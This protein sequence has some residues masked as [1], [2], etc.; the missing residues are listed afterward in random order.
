MDRSAMKGIELNASVA[1]HP[2]LGRTKNDPEE[3]NRPRTRSYGK[4]KKAARV[5]SW[6][7]EIRKNGNKFELHG[8]TWTF[9]N[10]VPRTRSLGLKK[11][12]PRM[13]YYKRNMRHPFFDPKYQPEPEDDNNPR[14]TIT[15]IVS[16]YDKSLP[17]DTITSLLR[18]H[19]SSCGEITKVYI[20]ADNHDSNIHNKYAF[21]D[22]TG[23]GAK[24]KAL[25]LSGSDVGGHKLLVRFK[26]V[27]IVGGKFT[28][29]EAV[30][31]SEDNE[32]YHKHPRITDVLVSGYHTWLPE[33]S[34]KSALSKHFS[35]CGEV[36]DV[37]IS[38]DNDG[39]LGD[40][41]AIQIWGEGAAEKARELSGSDMGGWKVVVEHCS[42]EKDLP[43]NRIYMGRSHVPKRS[44]GG[45]FY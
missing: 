3:S 45:R 22:I 34:L 29:K 17:E 12:D 32:T 8:K 38:I 6:F 33:E 18:E 15:V 23:V 24:E 16:G 30:R 37:I 11:D 1:D 9:G 13:D 20:H 14:R 7:D 10:P 35:S 41:A 19:F 4:M 40:R 42:G 43:L 2:R 44:R 39:L 36:E 26:P 25:Q 21:V 27:S 28:L 31:W 5:T